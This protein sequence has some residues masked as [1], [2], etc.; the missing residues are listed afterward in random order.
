MPIIT[1]S[2]INGIPYTLILYSFSRIVK[3]I[4]ARK[5]GIA[6]RQPIKNG[7]KI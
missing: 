1:F 7:I 2:T 3:T 6:K 5:K 4:E